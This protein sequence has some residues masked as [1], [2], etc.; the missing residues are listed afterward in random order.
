MEARI[1]HLEGAYVQ[2]SDR[3]NSIDRRLDSLESRIETRFVQVD[4][5]FTALASE[6]NARFASLSKDTK[7]QFTWLV[8]IVI[9]MALATIGTLGT[10]VYHGAAR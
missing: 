2:V 8:G 7:S 3:L 1:A 9:G 6:M 5:R 4:N 10:L